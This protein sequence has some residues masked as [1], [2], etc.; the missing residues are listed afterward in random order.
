MIH[1]TQADW[2]EYIKVVNEWQEDAFQQ[3]VTWKRVVVNRGIH[4]EGDN[5]RTENIVIRGLVQYNYFRSWPITKTSD[6]G[7]TDKQSML[8]FLNVKYLK[9]NGWANDAGQLLFDPG[10]DRFIINGVTYKSS[11]ESQ[12]A[13]A[14]NQPLFFYTVLKR[15]ELNTGE[16][17]YG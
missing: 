6:A 9:E 17:M 8:L 15:E 14:H 4:G 12:A 3:P 2:D 10:L 11:G 5:I 1:M 13:Q 16:E 7:E